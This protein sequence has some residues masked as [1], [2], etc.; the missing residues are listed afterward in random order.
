M[1]R[2]PVG[3]LDTGRG[4]GISAAHVSAVNG[5]NRQ[6]PDKPVR[7]WYL[8]LFFGPVTEVETVVTRMCSTV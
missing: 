4:T 1:V 5:F 3:Q 2:V 6:Y 7:L 8:Y